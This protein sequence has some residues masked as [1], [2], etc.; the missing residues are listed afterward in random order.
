MSDNNAPGTGTAHN[1][2]VRV[3]ETEPDDRPDTVQAETK[4]K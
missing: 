1:A 4:D 3:E 2:S